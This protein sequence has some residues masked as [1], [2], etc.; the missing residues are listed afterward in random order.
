[1]SQVYD[2][3]GICC[4][5]FSDKI[6]HVCTG[7]ECKHNFHL[8]CLL[9]RLALQKK[10][11][12]IA[13]VSMKCLVCPE[14]KNINAVLTSINTRLGLLKIVNDKLTTLTACMDKLQEDQITLDRH[15]LQLEARSC[16]NGDVDQQETIIEQVTERLCALRKESTDVYIEARQLEL[17][18]RMLND[19]LVNS[20]IPEIP[21]EDLIQTVI[22]LGSMIDVPNLTH[23]SLHYAEKIGKKGQSRVRSIVVKC[24]SPQLVEKV[25][26]YVNRRYPSSLFKLRQGVIK[27]FPNINKNN[28]W[29]TNS[30]VCLRITDGSD[31]IKVYPS[32]DL[33]RI[34]DSWHDQ[35][36]VIKQQAMGYLTRPEMDN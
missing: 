35:V 25:P 6:E 17:E 29:I 20:G 2:Y 14:S 21:S 28:I 1:M 23:D 30:C 32:M 36:D 11:E 16:S 10:D 12:A 4:R 5:Q 19:Q 26:L 9:I 18:S 7:A 27:K 33:D 13:S 3:C 34:Q 8:T 22:R 15:V 31:L 24:K